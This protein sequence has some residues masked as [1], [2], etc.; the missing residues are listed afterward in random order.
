MT[1]TKF[2]VKVKRGVSNAPAYVQRIDLT[3][4]HMTTNRKLALVMGK[5]MAQDAVNSLQ[6]SR[7]NP[8]LVSLQVGP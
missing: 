6:T 8:E 2:V 3:S 5:F 7:C 1:N 4:I